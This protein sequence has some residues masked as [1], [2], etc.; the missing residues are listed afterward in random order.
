M[1][2]TAPNLFVQNIPH[3]WPLQKESTYGEDYDFWFM[4]M[5]HDSCAAK[6]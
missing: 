1:G 4:C 5:M 6:I 3:V 2:R